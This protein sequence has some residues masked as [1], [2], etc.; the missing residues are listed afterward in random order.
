[1]LAAGVRI[2]SLLAPEHGIFGQ[3]D[4]E[5]IGHSKDEKTGL[6]VWSLYAGKNRRP[7]AEML[8]GLD[9]LVFDIQDIGTRFYTYPATMLNAMEEAAKHKIAFYVLDRPNPIN[10]VTVE[11]PLLGAGLESFVAAYKL[12]LRHA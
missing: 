11:G 6:K 8:A 4:H 5:N 12:P 9:A 7:S 1:M 10:G 2:T 3:E